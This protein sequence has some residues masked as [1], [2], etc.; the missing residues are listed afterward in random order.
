M[1]ITHHN[2]RYLLIKPSADDR[3]VD[4]LVARGV[5][6]KFKGYT[7]RHRSIRWMCARAIARFIVYPTGVRSIGHT[8]GPLPRRRRGG[9]KSSSYAISAPACSLNTVSI[10]QEAVCA[11]TTLRGKCPYVREYYA[12]DQQAGPVHSSSHRRGSLTAC[13]PPREPYSS[14]SLSRR[15]PTS[16]VHYILAHPFPR[17]I[18][19][20]LNC[21]ALSSTWQRHAD[22]LSNHSGPKICHHPL[23]EL[24]DRHRDSQQIDSLP[25]FV[26]ILPFSSSLRCVNT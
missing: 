2:P 6:A 12:S 15:Y 9:S 1:A 24:V 19:H 8:R 21:S 10:D 3:P 13:N 18:N 14:V 11:T 20:A 7:K 17:V 26:C 16:S 22:T 23:E 5:T 25:A 4:Q